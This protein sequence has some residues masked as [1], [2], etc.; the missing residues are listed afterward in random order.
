MIAHLF[1]VLTG[2]TEQIGNEKVVSQTESSGWTF[3]VE[4]EQRRAEP[5]LVLEILCVDV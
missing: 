5:W 2:S 3:T 1:L 4:G